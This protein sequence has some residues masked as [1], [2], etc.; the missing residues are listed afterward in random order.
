[1]TVTE[2][3]ELEE[4]SDLYLLEEDPT[5]LN[6][7][8]YETILRMLTSKDVADHTIAQL[9]LNNCNVNKSILWIW[10]LA[11]SGYSSRMV[12]L[13]TKASRKFRDDSRLFHIANKN[14]YLFVSY[15]KTQELLTSE[16]FMFLKD[17][18]INHVE[19]QCSNNFFVTSFTLNDDYKQ[20]DTSKL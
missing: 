17:D 12:N 4:K 18:L 13:R 20:F 3:I 6:A 2:N 10:K 11:K 1:M 8:K 7:E 14:A 9:L 5:I 15:L 19:R 16:I